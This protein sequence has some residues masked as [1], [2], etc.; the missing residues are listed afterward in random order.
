M[1]KVISLTTIPPRLPK[2]QKTL[3]SLDRQSVD[4]VYLNLPDFC[5]KT[6]SRYRLP[7]WLMSA[8]WQRLTV[9]YCGVDHGPATKIIPTLEAER[10][11]DTQILICDDDNWYEDDWSDSYFDRF[12]T[13]T[14]VCG[15]GANTRC[16]ESD[17]ISENRLSGSSVKSVKSLFDGNHY[18]FAEAFSGLLVER[19]DLDP[20]RLLELAGLS[21]ECFYADD[22]VF[23]KLLSEHKLSMTLLGLDNVKMHWMSDY[24]APEW[25]LA[26]G[27]TGGNKYTY[28]KA[29]PKLLGIESELDELIG[30]S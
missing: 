30:N 13:G 7:D 21:K 22:L 5:I 16:V 23:S 27:I 17:L 24:S 4:V 11:A 28:M 9:H 1:R 20:K 15:N 19:S 6:K 25:S 26:N 8:Q 3:E 2:L 18:D 29:L 12:V 10:D 14:F